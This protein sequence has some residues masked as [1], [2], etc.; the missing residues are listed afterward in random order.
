MG[1]WTKRAHCWDS[2]VVTTMEI[3]LFGL[4][5]SVLPLLYYNLRLVCYSSDKVDQVVSVFD[6]TSYLS[7]SNTTVLFSFRSGK[8]KFLLHDLDLYC[9]SDPFD[10]IHLFFKESFQAVGSQ[11]D[12]LGCWCGLI[13]GECWRVATLLRCIRVISRPMRDTN[14]YF[15]EDSWKAIFLVRDQNYVSVSHYY[16]K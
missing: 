11:V 14:T 2:V 6:V 13:V 10:P 5:L 12:H 16:N 4:R 3:V 1:N 15:L 9:G 7:S 8:L